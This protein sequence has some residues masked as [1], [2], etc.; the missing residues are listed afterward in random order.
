MNDHKLSDGERACLYALAGKGRAVAA[1]M[2]EVVL[3]GLECRGL[4]ERVVLQSLPLE[5]RRTEYRLTLAGR[6]LVD[7]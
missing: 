7:S 3:R 5:M 1:G 6:A 4:V 2:D